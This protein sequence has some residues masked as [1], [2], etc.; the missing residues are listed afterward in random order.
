MTSVA[1]RRV[2]EKRAR[3]RGSRAVGAGYGPAERFRPCRCAGAAAAAAAASLW[4]AA[5]SEGSEGWR[6]PPY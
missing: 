2:R 6:P 4:W 3:A 1:V 5:V